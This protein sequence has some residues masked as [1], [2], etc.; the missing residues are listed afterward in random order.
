MG[1]Y[2]ELHKILP[3]MYI[4]K[5]KCFFM[6]AIM[7]IS[8]R[9]IGGS[10]RKYTDHFKPS[11]I[12]HNVYILRFD[13]FPIETIPSRSFEYLASCRYLYMVKTQISVIQKDAWF[14]LKSLRHLSLKQNKLTVIKSGIFRHLLY[15]HYLGLM[16]NLIH[17]IEAGAFEDL[18]HLEDLGL[19]YNKIN[20]TGTDSEVWENFQ[21]LN[22]F[23][24]GSNYAPVL[25]KNSFKHL[26]QVTN[27]DL[28]VCEISV[29][30]AG[31]FNGLPRLNYLS[32]TGNNLK[33][34]EWNVFNPA[35]FI[36]H[37]DLP[38]RPSK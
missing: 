15:L 33:T 27:I 2:S 5:K 31:A 8:V 29:I 35:D 1:P 16:N 6:S 34:L 28:S 13:D 23:S 10:I 19:S 38:G 18:P 22:Y 37:P 21:N 4:S 32:L 25:Y 12:P 20:F 36:I 24:L 7:I 3:N 17:I 26:T 30:E 9:I 11:E 14:G